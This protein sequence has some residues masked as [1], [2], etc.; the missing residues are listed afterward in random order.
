MLNLPCCLDLDDLDETHTDHNDSHSA[1]E[2]SD[3]DSDYQ[4]RDEKSSTMNGLRNSSSADIETIK[5]SSYIADSR[6]EEFG[7]CGGAGQTEEVGD[8]NK[9]LIW[10]ILKQLRPGMD[11]SKVVLPTFILEPR[12]F[13]EKLCDHY[14]HCDLLS[15]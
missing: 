4:D 5:Q 6:V 7:V 10:M 13:L 14:Y 9:S 1:E 8:E 15:R 11:L 12:S 2:R 3:S